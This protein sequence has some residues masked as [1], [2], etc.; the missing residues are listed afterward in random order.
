MTFSDKIY[1]ELGV[2][3]L[4]YYLQSNVFWR[5]IEAMSNS[6]SDTKRIKSLFNIRELLKTTPDKGLWQRL[7]WTYREGERSDRT[8]YL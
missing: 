7:P 4:P 2:V 3:K 8:S 6:L 1:S 5:V